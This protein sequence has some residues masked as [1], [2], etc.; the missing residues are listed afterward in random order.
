MYGTELK[1][2]YKY[3]ESIECSYFSIVKRKEMQSA[4]RV[5]PY[6]HCWP[7]LK[8]DKIHLQFD[9]SCKRWKIFLFGDPVL[10]N[11]MTILN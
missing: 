9:K 3:E 11:F 1:I 6:F 5:I 2:I 10:L 7:H 8:Q 4:I